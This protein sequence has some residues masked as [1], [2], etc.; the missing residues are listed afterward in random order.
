MSGSAIFAIV[1]IGLIVVALAFFLIRIVLAL[2][3]VIDT[4]G[5]VVFGVRAVAY[6]TEPITPVVTDINRNLC[7]VAGALEAEVAKANDPA[8]VSVMSPEP[9]PPAVAESPAP[10]PLPPEDKP[11]TAT[12]IYR[13]LRRPS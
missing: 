6:R 7:A 11:P 8:R 10:P 3:Q 12:G 1:V 9:H 4:L 13:S 2:H 5:K